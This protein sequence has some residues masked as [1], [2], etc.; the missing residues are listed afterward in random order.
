MKSVKMALT[1][2]CVD[3]VDTV[4][5]MMTKKTGA[6][7]SRL[8]KAKLLPRVAHQDKSWEMMQETTLGGDP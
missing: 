8:F 4:S 6:M 1:S 5:L 3:G 7:N 2:F